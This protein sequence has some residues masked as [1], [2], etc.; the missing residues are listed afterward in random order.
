MTLR[1]THRQL[2]EELKAYIKELELQML[3]LEQ[4]VERKEQIIR[5]LK[6]EK[7]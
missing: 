7:K 2:I 5:S 3:T 4:T 6:A 1:Y